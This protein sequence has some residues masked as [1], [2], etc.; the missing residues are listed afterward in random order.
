MSYYPHYTFDDGEYRGFGRAL[1]DAWA[2]DRGH[3]LFFKPF[4]IK[5]LML[6][7][8]NGEIDLKYPDNRYWGQD[9]KAAKDVFYSEKV[10]EYIDGLSVKPDLIGKGPVAVKKLGTLRGFTP[11][12]WLDDIDA[13]DVELS[14]V[15]TLSSL[16][17]QTLLGRIDAAYANVSV[18]QYQLSQVG[19]SNMLQFDPGLKHT[20][21]FYHLSSV[22]K[23]ELI[24]DFD[25]WLLE[26]QERV[27]KLK[28]QFGVLFP[29]SIH[30]HEPDIR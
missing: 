19:Q 28:Q 17:S 10:V 1:L 25:V 3:Q 27:Q 12:A 21:D 22:G 2:E 15:N 24:K 11:W 16:I 7:L 18:V 26:N 8:V 29:T 23:P 9:V 20:R 4:P 5:R 30:S 6:S 14:E 13:G